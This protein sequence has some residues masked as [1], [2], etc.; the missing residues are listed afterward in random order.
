MYQN[1]FTTPVM[2]RPQRKFTVPLRQLESIYIKTMEV[3]C[4]INKAFQTPIIFIMMQMFH[5]LIT[6][7]HMTYHGT[8]FRAKYTIHELCII[9]LWT[10][11]QLVKV[12]AFASSGDLLKLEVNKIV[13]LLHNI[14]ID[15]HTVRVMS[16]V[17]HFSSLISYYNPEV[18]IYG[19]FS[20]D[21][22][23]SFNVIASVTTYLIILVQFDN[24]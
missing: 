6:N 21:A 1:N 7:S 8:I 9:S 2:R 5:A 24:S 15:R 16:E 18:L 3:K 12:Y 13:Q 19:F 17:Q 20:L 22:T 10:I 11:M 23:L 4:E 14:P